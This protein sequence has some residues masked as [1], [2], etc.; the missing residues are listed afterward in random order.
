MDEKGDTVQARLL[1]LAA[2]LGGNAALAIGPWLVRLADTGPVS[3]GFWRLALALPF[4]FLLAGINKERLSAIPPKS[5]GLLLIGG[6]LFGLDIASWNIGIE[7][8]RLA[9]ST[10]FGNAG[11]IILMVWSF[12]LLRRLPV[13]RE[14]PAI[15]AALAGAAVLLGRSLELSITNFRGD[16]FCL[17]AGVL[18]AAYLLLLQDARKSFGSWSVL[19]ISSTSSTLVL[20][21]CALILGEAFWPTDWTPVVLLALTS[22]II[23]QGLL[24]YA[25]RLFSPLVIGIALLTQPAVAAL[26]GWWQFGEVLVPLDVVGIALVSGALVLARASAP[27]RQ[28]ARH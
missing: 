27:K 7:Q 23:G 9:N 22:Q 26:I 12:V 21:I 15:I 13:G 8:T 16:L 10:L 24:V 25:L 5:I 18:Y 3:A 17:L 6:I 2:L 1:G 14:W 4:L 20:L 19:A 28:I 11:S